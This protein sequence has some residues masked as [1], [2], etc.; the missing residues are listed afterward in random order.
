M[1]LYTRKVQ[2]S[3]TAKG[4]IEMTRIYQQ[5]KDYKFDEGARDGRVDSNE[6]YTTKSSFGTLERAIEDAWWWINRTEKWMDTYPVKIVV[7]N[8]VT[9][10]VLWTWVK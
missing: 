5:I 1:I 3:S 6:V 7:I 9:K 2:L 4:I 8:K 10:E